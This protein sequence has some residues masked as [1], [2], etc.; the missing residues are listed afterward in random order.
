MMR[1][2]QKKMILNYYTEGTPKV[3]TT[4]WDALAT[5]ECFCRDLVFWDDAWRSNLTQA[6]LWSFSFMHVPSSPC[7]TALA[8][9]LWMKF[10]SA[11][12]RT[13]GLS[14]TLSRFEDASVAFRNENNCFWAC[15][16]GFTVSS[17][18]FSRLPS[19]KCTESICTQHW[20]L[21]FEVLRVFSNMYDICPRRRRDIES[22]LSN[23]SSQQACVYIMEQIPDLKKEKTP[24]RTIAS[25]CPL[26]CSGDI[27]SP[28]LSSVPRVVVARS[29]VFASTMKGFCFPT[30]FPDEFSIAVDSLSAGASAFWTYNKM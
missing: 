12:N 1:M 17:G 21:A 29:R 28:S 16:S 20:F 30:K 23:S 3:T 19:Y 27:P 13:V 10:D 6:S 25:N 22:R 11:L 24:N 26:S 2:R 4:R 7:K 15:V 8:A 5:V 18:R 9:I 14:E